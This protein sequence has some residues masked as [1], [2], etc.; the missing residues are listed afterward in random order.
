MWSIEKGGQNL[1]EGEGLKQFL[2]IDKTANAKMGVTL[3]F[4]FSSFFH[5]RHFQFD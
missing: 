3:F 4:D 1:E 5:F 2:N